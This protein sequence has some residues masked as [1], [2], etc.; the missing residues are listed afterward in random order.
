MEVLF[1]G[2]L[3]QDLFSRRLK[4]LREEKG[5]TMV[6]LASIIGMSQATISEWEKGN[7][8]PRAGALQE[9]ANYFDVPM[10]YFFKEKVFPIVDMVNIPLY[11]SMTAG[12][13]S[14][15]DGL[16]DEEVEFMKLPTRFLGEYSN[17]EDLIAFRVREES[18]NLLFPYGSPVV[19]KK[20]AQ[21]EVK[22]GDIVVYCFDDEHAIGRFRR[23]ELK[24]VFVFS[25]ESTTFFHDIV[26]PF[27][28]KS[29]VQIIAK[30]IWYGVSI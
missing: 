7:K 24:E 13:L 11:P 29:N 23:N 17:E 2:N 3:V 16:S 27:N 26:I 22:D 5:I 4:R 20:V 21:D 10:E 1:V 15:V 8:F 12:A 6:E 18:M 28:A 25:S 14:I 19:A 30:L 9:L